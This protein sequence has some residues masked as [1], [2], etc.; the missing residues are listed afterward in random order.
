MTMSSFGRLRS[1]ARIPLV[2]KRIFF[3]VSR[4]TMGPTQLDIQ[5]VQNTLYLQVEQPGH[6]ADH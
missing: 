4:M 6:A 5:W 2:R 3:K 1:C